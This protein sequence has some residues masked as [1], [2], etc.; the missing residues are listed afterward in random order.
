LGWLLLAFGAVTLGASSGCLTDFSSPGSGDG[1]GAGICGNG[2]VEGA[3]ACDDGALNPGDGC[4]ATCHLEPGWN[5]FGEPSVC[6]MSCGNLALDPGEDCDGNLL[7]GATCETVYAGFDGGDLGCTEACFFDTA[8]CH[9][10]GCGDGMVGV[11][12]ECDDGNTSNVDDCLNNCSAAVCGD[13]YIRAGVEECDDAN[14]YDTDYCTNACQNAVCG[15]GFVWVGVE[16]CDDGN[17]SLTDGCPDGAM[18]TCQPAVC[19]DGHVW[20]GHETCDDQNTSNTDAC[21]S[22]CVAAT[23]GDGYVWS[24]NEQCD[25]GDT[26]NSNDCLTN[27]I[28]ATC[29]DG[30]VWV[31]HETCDDQNTSNTDACLSNCV[32]AFCGDGYIRAGSEACDDG[33]T[34]SGDGC[35]ASCTVECTGSLTTTYTGGDWLYPGALMFEVMAL[36]AMEL[37]GM[38]VSLEGDPTVDVVIYY[39]RGPY[40]GHESTQADWILHTTVS[41]ITAAGIHQPT[42]IPMPTLSMFSGELISL[43]VATTSSNQKI[44]S[45]VGTS[46][47][48]VYRSNSFLMVYEGI[49]LYHAFST[50]QYSP[51]VF[52]GTLYYDICP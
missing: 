6:A 19:G 34:S 25:D 51:R 1:G 46:E 13:G 35:S 47:G 41:G 5:C 37:T 29:G 44:F 9:L 32:A 4:D 22:S 52:N 27:C 36:T 43:Y 30:Y 38:D 28:H 7:G 20:E 45:N 49:S 15:D 21:P 16:V 18:G 3:E 31:G 48:A 39:R 8:N 12:E 11:N 42:S 50:T 26:S 40:A 10:P 24:G 2:I 23:C 33:N 14:V 17:A